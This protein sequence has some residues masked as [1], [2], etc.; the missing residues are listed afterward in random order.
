[1]SAW[2]EVEIALSARNHF[3]DDVLGEYHIAGAELAS[4]YADWNRQVAIVEYTREHIDHLGKVL[5]LS[6]CNSSRKPHQ[7]RHVYGSL[8]K[9]VLA[10]QAVLQQLIPVVGAENDDRVARTS[11]TLEHVEH[12][13]DLVIYHRYRCVVAA[14]DPL[15]TLPVH[16]V[17]R[18]KT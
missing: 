11:G 5:P 10:L 16:V 13:S 9:H 4:L 3:G 18:V 17:L 1:P 2:H 15:Q 12:L 6:R 7:Q 8:K 14:I